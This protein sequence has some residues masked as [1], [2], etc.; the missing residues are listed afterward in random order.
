MYMKLLTPRRIELDKPVSSRS[1]CTKILLCKFNQAF[2]WRWHVDNLI[3]ALGLRH[4]WAKLIVDE[5]SEW[6]QIASWTVFD[7]FFFA[8]ELEELERGIWCDVISATC[9]LMFGTV[10]FGNFHPAVFSG[11]EQLGELRPGRLQTGT[12]TAPSK[13]EEVTWLMGVFRETITVRTNNVD[14]AS[15]I[16]SL[17]HTQ[18]LVFLLCWHFFL[19]H[20]FFV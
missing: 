17:V 2:E 7:G 16:T 8:V 10:N 12:M 5:L 9:L 18:T 14:R 20:I 19:L 13:S 4:R 15:A 3:C 1:L 6:R 11:V